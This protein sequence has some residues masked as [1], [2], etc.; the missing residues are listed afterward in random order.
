MCSGYFELK[1]NFPIIQKIF[2]KYSSLEEFGFQLHAN[3]T[4]GHYIGIVYA[5]SIGETAGLKTGERIVG[6]NGQLIYPTN[7]HKEV[8]PLMKQNTMKTT[9]LVASEKVDK[10]RK[11]NNIAC[12]PWTAPS[13]RP[14]TSGAE[15]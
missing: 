3:Q 6:V 15:N 2:F 10:Y 11:K 7:T 12:Q 1:Q 4:I 13:A 9:L 5:G 14:P 8:V